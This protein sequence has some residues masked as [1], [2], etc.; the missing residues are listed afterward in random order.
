ML[1]E[2]EHT[3]K[4]PKCVSA[5][6]FSNPWIGW[7]KFAGQHQVFRN[8]FKTCG[9]PLMDSKGKNIASRGDAV[10]DLI[11]TDTEGINLMGKGGSIIED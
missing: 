1:G 5:P 4:N 11:F 6:G 7:E 10:L 3:V 8:V 2:V 9:M